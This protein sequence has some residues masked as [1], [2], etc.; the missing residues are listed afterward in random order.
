MNH[1]HMHM[2]MSGICIYI[3]IFFYVEQFMYKCVQYIFTV[4]FSVFIRVGLWFIQDLL[5]V[6]LGLV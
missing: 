2:Y 3:Y 1:D 5:R 6:Y 4:W